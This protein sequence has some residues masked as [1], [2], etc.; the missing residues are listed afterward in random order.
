MFSDVL[1]RPLPSQMNPN[2]VDDA[3]IDDMESQIGAE[4]DDDD[5]TIDP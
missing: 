1:K 3:D 4:P 2:Q 5:D